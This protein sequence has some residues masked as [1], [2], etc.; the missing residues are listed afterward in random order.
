MKNYTEIADDEYHND[1]P[2]CM[3]GTHRKRKGKNGPTCTH[4]MTSITMIHNNST[5]RY[6][7]IVKSQMMLFQITDFTIYEMRKQEG[8]YEELD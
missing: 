1:G 5:T 3:W 6:M 4:T 7:Y 8:H 2:T